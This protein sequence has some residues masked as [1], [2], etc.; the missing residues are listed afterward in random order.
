[1]IEWVIFG[2]YALYKLISSSSS[3]A[4]PAASAVTRPCRSI[5]FI[6]R[7]GVGK[8]ST[9]NALLGYP[10]FA[11]SAAHGTT[12]SIG[13]KSYSSD[14]VIRDTPGSMDDTS[15]MP[16]VWPAL[17]ESAIVVYTTAGQLY[18]VEL[19]FL[20]TLRMRQRLWDGPSAEHRKL[21]LYVNQC[22][23]REGTMTK[24]LRER[25]ELAIR[26]QVTS[27]I[28]SDRIAFGAASP[29]QNGQEQAPRVD[30]LR[31]LLSEL[32]AQYQP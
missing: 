15:Y 30:A 11:T 5:T 31:D 21:V 6:G 18:R 14:F 13:D 9:A 20:Q 23:T 4:R 28:T 26:A 16:L 24:A 19:E 7:T 17:E 29:K 3:G 10:A 25:E 22:D 1:M 27:W 2:G 8:S 12:T 32:M